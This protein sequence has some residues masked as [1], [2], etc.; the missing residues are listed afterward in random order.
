[1]KSLR[2]LGIALL[3][4]AL[5]TAVARPVAPTGQHAEAAAVAA[6]HTVNVT[7]GDSGWG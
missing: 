3:G 2:L 5:A 7:G 1:M 6:H 4:L